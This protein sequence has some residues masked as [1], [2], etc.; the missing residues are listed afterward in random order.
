LKYINCDLQQHTYLLK[1]LAGSY[2]IALLPSPP[3][4]LTFAHIST[5]GERADRLKENEG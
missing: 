1:V 3:H 4:G 2:A 5:E